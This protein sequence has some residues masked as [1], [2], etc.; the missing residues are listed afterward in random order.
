MCVCHTLSTLC[1]HCVHTSNTGA[2]HI[3]MNVMRTGM[4]AILI[5]LSNMYNSLT[6]SEARLQSETIFTINTTDLEDSLQYLHYSHLKV[7]P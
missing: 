6:E 4:L 5:P 2:K 3:H 1:V 7:R